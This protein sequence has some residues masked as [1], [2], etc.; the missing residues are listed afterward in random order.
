[1]KNIINETWKPVVGYEDKYLV[2]NIG[3]VKS[4]IF[5]RHFIKKTRLLNMGYFGISITT[6]I[7]NIKTR[8]NL[9]IHRLIAL[10]FI[11]N[12]ENK[13][14]VN[15][16][17][18]IKTDN[19]IE[20]L[21]WV[22]PSENQIHSC[23]VLGNKSHLVALKYSILKVRVGVTQLTVNGKYVNSFNSISDA[24]RYLK[25]K[26]WSHISSCCMGKRSSAYGY[27]WEYTHVSNQ[28]LSKVALPI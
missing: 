24:G 8:K 14:E 27:K 5:K 16:I 22:T 10:A 25:L 19:R 12:P 1:M 3:R 15:H 28:L 7:N 21:E 13:K 4:I 26:T 20:N 6:S 11:P 2:S 23:R 17:N 9:L 18:G